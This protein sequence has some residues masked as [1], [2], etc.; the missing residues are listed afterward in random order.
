MVPLTVPQVHTFLGRHKIPEQ[1][2]EERASAAVTSWEPEIAITLCQ[3]VN[4]YSHMKFELATTNLALLTS[5]PPRPTIEDNKVQILMMMKKDEHTNDDADSVLY[6]QILKLTS[7]I[8]GKERYLFGWWNSDVFLAYIWH[9]A[10]G[11]RMDQQHEP[12][13]DSS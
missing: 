13:H 2:W 10:T 12:R 6:V 7:V 9:L 1:C 4:Y 8:L 11:A 5:I 3:D